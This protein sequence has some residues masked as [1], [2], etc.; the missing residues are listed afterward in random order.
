MKDVIQNT[1]M[2]NAKRQPANL[3]RILTKAKFGDYGT[4]NVKKCGK[5]R[6]PDIIEGESFRLKVNPSALK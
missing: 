3:K 5:S 6:C 1:K 2:I 4:F